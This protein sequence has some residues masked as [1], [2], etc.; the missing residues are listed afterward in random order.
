[1]ALGW[2][3]WCAWAPLVA[4]D[5]AALC[6]AGVALGTWWHPPSLR[7]AGVALGDI[8]RRSTYGSGLALVALG[9][10]WS[11]VMPRHCAWQ[12]WHLALGDIY[13]RCAWQA[14][15][16][17]TSTGVALM[18]LGW[19]WWRLGAPGRRWCPGTVR[20]RRGTWWHPP[21]F[22]VEGV[23]LGVALMLLRWS[24]FGSRLL[25]AVE[26]HRS[27]V[28]ETQRCGHA[29]RKPRGCHNL[30]SDPL[31]QDAV[32]QRHAPA[33]AR[34]PP[35]CNWL[36]EYLPSWDPEMA[37]Y[38]DGLLRS[39][40][41]PLWLLAARSDRLS[42][43]LFTLLLTA[44]CLGAAGRR[45]R[46]GTLH[47]RR[48]TWWHPPSFRVEG[49]ALSDIDA[50]FA[51][52]AWPLFCVAGVAL[53]DM[54]VA[55][56]WQG[57]LMALRWLWWHA[58]A[59]LVAGDAAALCVAGMR[60]RWRRGTL[61]GRRGT[62]RQPPSFHVAGVALGDIYLRFAWQ[63][64]H[65]Q[66]SA[67]SLRGRRSTFGSGGALGRRWS[68]VTR[69]RHGT[70]RHPSSLAWQVWHLWHWAGSGG[71]LGRCWSP[72]APRLCVA[73]VALGNSCLRFAWQVW[74]SS[75][76]SLRG[77]R[78]TWRSICVAGVALMGWVWWRAWGPLVRESHTTLSHTHNFV[79]HNLSH[80]SLS[81][82]T[83]LPHTSLWRTTLSHTTL[84]HTFF[85]HNFVTDNFDTHTQLCHT[86]VFHTQLCHTQS[87]THTSLSRAISLTRIFV[88]HSFFT[89]NF[90]TH[91]HAHTHNFVTHKSFTHKF[92]TDNFVT[93]THNSFTHTH[94]TLSQTMFNSQVCHTQSFTHNFVTRT[95][96]FTHTTL[97]QSTLSYTAL[98]DTTLSQT[99][100]HTHTQL[101]HTQPFTHDF[102]TH[103][104]SFTH[105]FVTHT[106][107]IFH[108]QLCHTHMF[109]TQL[110]H[111]H[112]L[113]HT[114]L[115]HTQSFTHNLAHAPSFT[116]SFVT[117]TIFHTQLVTRTIF[118][119]QLCH[120]HNLSHT[121]LS[122]SHTI[123]H[124]QLCHTQP[125]TH[126]L[127]HAP[128]FTHSFVTHTIFHTQLV[129]RTIF[130]TQLCHTHNLSHT[131][132]SLSHTHNLSHTA[133][134]HTI[135]HTQLVTRTIFHTQ[136]CHTH[137]LSHTICHTHHLSH[138]TC[139]THHLSHTALSH[140]IFHTHTQSHSFV[141]HTHT[142][143]HTIC[144]T[145]HL[146]QQLV[147]RTI[148]HT[149]FVTHTIF[150]TQLCHTHHLSHTTLS[151]AQSF[152]H[153][154]VFVTHTIF[155]TQ[156]CHT[157]N[158]SHTTLSYTTL[159]I[160]FLEWSI[161]HHLLCPFFFLRA[162]STTFA[163]YWKK[164]AC[165]VIRS[166]N[167]VQKLP[168]ATV[169]ASCGEHVFCCCILLIM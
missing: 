136:L 52:Q 10:P 43:S 157:H 153:N 145:H 9:R 25:C 91:T 72:V 133:L 6:M 37:A 71:A 35:R 102:V 162:A 144:H 125:F 161:L 61:P 93:P 116:H 62:W 132:L 47:G 90:D 40:S 58:W 152:T 97:S 74:H 92:I 113:S 107:T 79:T 22:R 168:E 103:T 50:R 29:F 32:P 94:T 88:T 81:H 120:T 95:Q 151:H 142:I 4:G 158:L 68:P 44:R 1:M 14:W 105:D 117:H 16:L 11:P 59:P 147:T 163:D 70:W 7:V 27:L 135:F 137:N 30:H 33:C 119:T 118:H 36:C 110:C 138:T 143:F 38:L 8:Y 54:D 121:T 155:H 109:F 98:S 82:A 20:G 114:A 31:P 146:S 17:V 76:F 57:A 87:L 51:W 75:T 46:R 154:F 108:T 129:T 128:S 124:T 77:R 139:H 24:H 26:A 67:L 5:A 141:T 169:S 12:A 99:I 78:G 101:F 19:L 39:F 63:A 159:H 84:S 166:F 140:T 111:T 13:L 148:F 34:G 112:N 115:S 130:H 131:T 18:A 21:S 104:Q 15:H 106:H 156:L 167:W 164:L 134:S 42:N 45:W 49:V 127:S 126:N 69:G 56:A 150:H 73:G 86:H 55:F 64:R 28:L 165:G 89:H 66:T 23:A 3:W 160:Q 85:S 122:L 96:S 53:G 100:F 2:L 83:S 60:W 149:Q 123:F 41:E 65:C 48:G 80:T